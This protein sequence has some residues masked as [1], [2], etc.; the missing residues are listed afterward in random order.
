MKSV[1]LEPK[2]CYRAQMLT[3]TLREAYGYRTTT[4]CRRK[5]LHLGCPTTHKFLKPG[6]ALKSDH[7][8][9]YSKLLTGFLTGTLRYPYGTLRNAWVFKTGYHLTGL[10]T[11]TLRYPYGTLRNAQVLKMRY[12]LTGLLMVTLRYPYG[13]LWNSFFL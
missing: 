6:H 13:T 10:L 4:F 12:R 7:M 9:T 1:L 5:H 8:L 3:V 11:V 2:Q